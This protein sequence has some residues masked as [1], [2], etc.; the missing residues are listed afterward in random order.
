MAK[1]RTVRKVQRTITVHPELLKVFEEVAPDG[2]VSS[3]LCKAGEEK[4]LGMPL[5]YLSPATRARLLKL[6]LTKP[7]QL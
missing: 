5:S 4:V 1:K 3:F 2:N 6:G 7:D